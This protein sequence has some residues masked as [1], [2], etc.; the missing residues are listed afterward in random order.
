M[1]ISRNTLKTQAN[2]HVTVNV[3]LQTQNRPSQDKLNMSCLIR[4]K[5]DGATWWRLS[6]TEHFLQLF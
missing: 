2:E 4:D 1:W 3:T 5:G 6:T